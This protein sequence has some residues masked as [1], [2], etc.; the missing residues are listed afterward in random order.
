[1]FRDPMPMRA[2][3]CGPF[4]GL[5]HPPPAGTHT[6]K[7]HAIL[8]RSLDRAVCKGGKTRKQFLRHTDKIEC[9]QLPPPPPTAAGSPPTAVGYPSTA[10]G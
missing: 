10:A 5:L 4:E 3:D 2:H 8:G 1:M 7:K 6:K 9:S